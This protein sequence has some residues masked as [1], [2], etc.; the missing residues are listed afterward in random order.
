MY[1]NWTLR[2]ILIINSFYSSWFSSKVITPHTNRNIFYCISIK[3]SNEIMQV[4]LH[5]IGF[6]FF[7]WL[8]TAAYLKTAFLQCINYTHWHLQCKYTADTAAERCKKENH[9]LKCHKALKRFF[10]CKDCKCRTIGFSK[11]PKMACR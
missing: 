2:T 11:F 3:M 5:K 4:F 1:W 9:P 10:E 7:W 6:L 8:E